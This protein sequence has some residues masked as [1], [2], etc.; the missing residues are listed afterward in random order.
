MA[1]LLESWNKV[2]FMGQQNMP[3]SWPPGVARGWGTE[4]LIAPSIAHAS[5]RDG[6]TIPCS[7]FLAQETRL[8]LLRRYIPLV[9][10]ILCCIVPRIVMGY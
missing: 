8:E 9:F 7:R 1:G 6:D 4:G 2:T 5:Y 3:V 10:A